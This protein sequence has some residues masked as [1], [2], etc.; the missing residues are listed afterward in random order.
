V[1]SYFL[2]PIFFYASKLC[3][4]FNLQPKSSHLQE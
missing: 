3:D 1:A 2:R 4:S